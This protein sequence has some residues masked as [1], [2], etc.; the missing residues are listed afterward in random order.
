MPHHVDTYWSFRSP[1]SYLAT[2]R[3]VALAAEYKVEFTIKPVYPI[4]VRIDGFFKRANPLWAPYLMRDTARVAQIN[5]L[6]YRWPRPDPVLMD[7]KTGEVPSEQPHIYRLTQLGQVAAEM[8]RGLAFVSEVSTL[9]WSGHTDDWHLGD[10]LAK[11]TARA[12]L[13]LARMDAIVVAEGARLHEA[14]ENNQKALQQAG[15]WGVPTFVHQ[16][17]PFFGQDRLDA[18]MW[19]MQSTGLKHRDNPPVTPEFL[20]GTWRL[21]RW[22]LW[23][24]GA[25]SRL[26]L[27]ERGTGVLIYERQGRMA[28]FLQH[29]DWH[30]APAGQKPASTD[31]FAYSGQWRLEGKDVV[32]A[33]DHASIGAWTGQEVRRA[34]RRT[35]AD[36]L[37]LIAPPETNA[38]GQVNSNI[39]HWRRA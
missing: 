14:I 8:G 20:C 5:G 28:G 34:A 29:T 24:D 17:E 4:A 30:K 31:F 7:I 9:I 19:R 21:D 11:A 32:H 36:G 16:G 12:G 27:G 39:L 3:M 35:A 26:P 2:P 33:I 13:D 38:K 23:R 15:H 25:F 18:L 22:E 6:P 10:H 37:E 1:Y